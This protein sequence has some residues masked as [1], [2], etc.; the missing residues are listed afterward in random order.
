MALNKDFLSSIRLVKPCLIKEL[1]ERK[2]EFVGH[3]L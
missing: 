2:I 3:V 1:F